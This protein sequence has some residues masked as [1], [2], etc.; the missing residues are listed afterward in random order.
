MYQH[1]FC[2][3]HGASCRFLRDFPAFEGPV[4]SAKTAHVNFFTAARRK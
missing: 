1:V 4:A 3:G 2:E